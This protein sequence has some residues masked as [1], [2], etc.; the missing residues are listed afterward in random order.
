M[1]MSHQQ[2]AGQNHNLQT[3][4]KSFQNAAKFKYLETAVTYQDCI[5]EEIK[6]RFKS[7][8]V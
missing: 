5:Y 3:D 6:I 2:N 8:N 7:G 1:V 4:N